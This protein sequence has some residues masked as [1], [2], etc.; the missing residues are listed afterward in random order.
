MKQSG[1]ILLV[2][3]D[4]AILQMVGDRLEMEGYTLVTASRGE[5]ALEK[6]PSIIPNLI[7]LDIS[8]PGLGGL[9]FLRRL[10]DFSPAPTA[11]IM[12]FTGRHELAPFF[13]D[14]T[15]ASFVPKTTHPEIFIQKVHELVAG[16]RAQLDHAAALLRPVIRKKLL[17]VENDFDL[18]DHLS[19]FFFRHGFE[20]DPRDGGHSLLENA[21]RSQPHLILIKYLLPH[22]NGPELAELLG[23][24]PPTQTIP[25]V[26]YDETGIQAGLRKHPFVKSLVASSKDHILLKTVSD[27]LGHPSFSPA[28]T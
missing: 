8:M 14:S 7:I 18:R 1:T 5:Q 21:T 22:H 13:A 4:P 19:R 28:L 25:I 9:G 2:D 26:L 17:L 15:V 27:I 24:H 6:L 3:D 20:V 12:V 23:T 11:P 16:H 10:T